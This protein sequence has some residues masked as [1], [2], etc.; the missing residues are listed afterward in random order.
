MMYEVAIQVSFI[1][2]NG[3]QIAGMVPD[4]INLVPGP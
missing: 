2:L 4:F 1:G 3:P